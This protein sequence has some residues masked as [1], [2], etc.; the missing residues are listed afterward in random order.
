VPALRIR[1]A[2]PQCGV[3]ARIP[4]GV[5]PAKVIAT[6]RRYFHKHLDQFSSAE[7][8]KAH[9][10]RVFA[11]LSCHACHQGGVYVAV[12]RSGRDEA[13]VVEFELRGGKYRGRPAR[14]THAGPVWKGVVS[15]AGSLPGYWRE[16]MNRLAPP[17][18]SPRLAT[19]INPIA[20]SKL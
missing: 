20:A 16:P 17:G 7:D 14:P 18:P 9:V 8:V 12:R 5:A 2:S 19:R 10:E 13:T 11:E 3:G 6:T 1:Y 15:G 4:L